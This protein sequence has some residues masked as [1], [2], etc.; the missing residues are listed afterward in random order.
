MRQ[1]ITG[2]L[3]TGYT[4]SGVKL[5]GTSGRLYSGTSENDTDP[6]NGNRK[7]AF[8]DENEVSESDSV[9]LELKIL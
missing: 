6:E 3:I 5:A 2:V 4:A 1:S 9:I 8:W 7:R